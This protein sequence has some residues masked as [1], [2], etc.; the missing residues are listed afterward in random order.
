MPEF[1]GGQDAMGAFIH[2]K[3]GYPQI[4][5][6]GRTAY[7]SF[8]ISETGRTEYVK[9]LRGLNPKID[10]S[11]VNAVRHMPRWKPALSECGKPIRIKY[12]IPIRINFE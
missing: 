2:K 10:S 6:G 3:I 7:C 11:I 4:K 5:T 8:D 1:P 12:T 9:I